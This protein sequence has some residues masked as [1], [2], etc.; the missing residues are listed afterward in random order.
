MAAWLTSK[1]SS[2]LSGGS[3]DLIQ[4]Q[5]AARD[6]LLAENTAAVDK[7]AQA[8]QELAVCYNAQRVA[9]PAFFNILS[10]PNPEVRNE[11]EMAKELGKLVRAL[12]MD[13][14]SLGSDLDKISQ[15]REL[16]ERLVSIWEKIE[17]DYDKALANL[18][19]VIELDKKNITDLTEVLGQL[20]NLGVQPTCR[21]G[22]SSQ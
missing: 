9:Y 16:F 5:V 14:S 20:K 3:S 2:W 4:Q 22:L 1:V 11:R 15:K 8:S 18:D 19:K 17:A 12:T 13:L 10:Q 6:S 7:V 21:S